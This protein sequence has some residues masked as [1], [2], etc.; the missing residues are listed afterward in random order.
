MTVYNVYYTILETNSAEYNRTERRALDLSLQY[1][2]VTD[3]TSLIVVADNN[4]T[5]DNNENGGQNLALNQARVPPVP[6][7]SSVP[8][9]PPVPPVPAVPPGSPA[10]ESIACKLR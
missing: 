5:V 8:A 4:F 1:N 7:G 10:R 9:A 3:L 6:Q 2:F